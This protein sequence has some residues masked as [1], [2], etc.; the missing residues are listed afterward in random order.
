MSSLFTPDPVRFGGDDRGP[1]RPMG[2]RR[3]STRDRVVTY[4][5]QAVDANGSVRD[6][7]VVCES[8]DEAVRRVRHLGLRPV[9]IRRSRSAA[10]SREMSIPGLGRRV[11]GG[12]LAVLSRQFATMVNA[13]VPL[14]R[15]LVVLRDQTDDALLNSTFEQMRL[16][17]EGGDSLSEAISRHPRVFDRLFVSMIRSGE[18]SGALDL[19]LLQLATTLERSAGMRRKIRS[20]LAYPIAV[21]FMVLGVMIAML[22]FVV[23]QFSSIYNDLGGTLPL[24]TRILVGFSDMFTRQLP[25]L[26]FTTAALTLG[27]R[28]WKRTE[29]GAWRW[30]AMKL[31]LPLVG[32]LLLKSSMARF[33]R[34][35]SVLTKSGVPVL[36]TLRITSET[37]GNAVLSR[38]LLETREAVRRGEQIA[39]NLAKREVF[40]AMVVQLVAVGE[41]AG[42]L[43]Q[44]FDTIGSSYE[45]EVE[46]A[47][48]GFAALIEPL[49]MAF[50]GVVV[51]AMVVAL[52]LPMF[53]VIDLVQ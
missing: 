34:T 18:A 35:M 33:G 5:Y 11:K 29:S 41:E 48:A 30:D 51:G 2:A 4:R 14:L 49:M 42:A 32:E 44:M 53:R 45:E 12:D 1:K 24:P 52:Y 3:S 46:T 47:V 26:A 28:R 40:P 21:L 39:P 23:P 43:D 15:A 27:L 19:V 20:A 7:R 31:R 25:L 37:L 50:I 16:D 10:F 38:A 17:V 8:E 6:G 36:E 9:S 13:G 22:T